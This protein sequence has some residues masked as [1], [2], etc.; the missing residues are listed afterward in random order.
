VL[1][2]GSLPGKLADCTLNDPSKLN[3]FWL[4][5]ILQV[6]QPSKERPSLSA[7]LPLWGKMLIPKSQWIRFSTM[8]R[9]SQ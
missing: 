5:E 7:L 8:T 1:E 2:S 9:S 4:K 3:Y 6:D